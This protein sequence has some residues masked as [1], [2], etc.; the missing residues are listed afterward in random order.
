MIHTDLFRCPLCDAQAAHPVVIREHI[1]VFQNVVFAT[2]EEALN[3]PKVPFAMAVCEHCG[4]AFNAR[5]EPDAVMYDARYNNDVPSDAFEK[6]CRGIVKDLR[7]RYHITRGVVCDVGAGKGRFLDLFTEEV[8][9]TTGLGIDPSCVAREAT[10]DRPV[11]LVSDIFRPEHVSEVPELVVCRHTLEHI[12]KPLP[13][14][15]SVHEALAAAPDVPIFFEVPDLEWILEHGAFWDFCYEHCNY[16]TATTLANTLELAGFAVESVTHAFGGQYLWAHA[17]RR[18]TG[19]ASVAH[20]QGAMLARA[21]TYAAEE[22][23]R[24]AEA[25]VR[26]RND[27][28]RGVCALWGMS[29]K[30]VLFGCMVD[31]ACEFIAGGVDINTKKQGKYAPLTAMTIQSPEWLRT[32]AGR[33]VT[34]FVMNPNYADEIRQ[35]CQTLG[36]DASF[37]MV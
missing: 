5:F 26:V 7:D 28:E 27:S 37:V 23:R 34:V 25:K 13:F 14:L 15:H 11:R 32:H 18:A 4:F 3:A 12:P 9:G 6:Y 36:I 30:G 21:R 19:A 29:T 24:I 10:P 33:A 2:R 35:T 20:N 22:S 16:F 17:R 31:P 8:P 1:P